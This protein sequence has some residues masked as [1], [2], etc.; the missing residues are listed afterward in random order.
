MSRRLRWLGHRRRADCVSA[1]DALHGRRDGVAVAPLQ[2]GGVV[3]LALL[4][5]QVV[6]GVERDIAVLPAQTARVEHVHSRTVAAQVLPDVPAHHDHLR[7]PHVACVSRPG[8]RRG[9]VRRVD[10]DP[11]EGRD[12]QDPHVVVLDLF[13]VGDEVL[14]SVHVHLRRRAVGRGH[15]DGAGVDAYLGGRPAGGLLVPLR[16]GDVVYVD[17][18]HLGEGR[19]GPAGQTD[20]DALL[21]V[22][23]HVDENAV[24]TLWEPTR[25][26]HAALGDVAVYARRACRA[27]IG[28]GVVGVSWECV[29]EE[30]FD[31]DP[32]D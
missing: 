2:G 7:V 31:V 26:L 21:R 14:A 10:L 19:V 18:V 25:V 30:A 28:D 22:P 17:D 12:G 4:P 8:A 3:A 13:A 27:G 32:S 29:L 20:N 9:L 24:C 23:R 1:H 16:R 5:V 15:G 11:R 6:L